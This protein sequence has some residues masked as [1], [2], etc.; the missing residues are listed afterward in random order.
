MHPSR[1]PLRRRVA[2][3]LVPLGAALMW[4]GSGLALPAHAAEGADLRATF[5][6]MRSRL[7]S[8]PLQRP[9]V[10]ESTDTATG[11]KGDV[12]AVVNHPLQTIDNAL[13]QP[14]QWCEALLLHLNNRACTVSNGV[15]GGKQIT[16][17]VVRKYDQPVDSAFVL[18]FSFRVVDASRDHL[19]FALGAA[20][21]P[22]GTSNYRI[23]LEAIALDPQHSFLHF[24]YAYDE[25][26]LAHTATQ[27]YLAT[28]GRNKVGFTIVGHKPDGKPDYIR[29]TRG[30]VERNAMRY[31]LA[32]DSYLGTA[33][34]PSSRWNAWFTATEKYP[35]Q[36]HEV[37][38]ATYLELKKED[39]GSR[40]SLPRG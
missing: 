27:A 33:A 10:L 14:A 17:S 12:F 9:M 39:A 7:A 38:R 26:F 40:G 31:F 13:A 37:G 2:L 11:L 24:S 22:L 36:L 3:A 29:G 5:Q 16:L 32:V 25:G 4:G 21:G 28:F 8:T 20:S 18:P 6:A 15:D 1:L 35:E 23:A 19:E 30:L 34:D